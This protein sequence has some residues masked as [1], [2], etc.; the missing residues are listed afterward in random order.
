MPINVLMC[1]NIDV[2]DVGIKEGV[3]LL[4]GS[5]LLTDFK[6]VMNCFSAFS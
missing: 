5:Y 4:P 3:W 6:K 1:M 2:Y